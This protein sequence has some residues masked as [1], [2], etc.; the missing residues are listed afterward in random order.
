MVNSGSSANLLMTAALFYTGDPELKLR[1]GDEI[2]V[3]A[4]SWSTTYF[5]LS[6]FGL[7]QKF[8]DVDR[9]TLNYD[10]DQLRSA[11]SPKT[12]AIMIV[13]LL[14]NPNDFRAINDMVDGKNIVLMEDNCE[15]VALNLK[16]NLLVR[17]EKLEVFRAFFP[18]TSQQW[19]VE[20]L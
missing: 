13:N 6:Q 12:R 2:I 9:A 4:I 7:M 16:I 8:V 17:L 20:W 1:P 19:K 18:I 14:G 11:I 10:L 3:P 15:S 5:P